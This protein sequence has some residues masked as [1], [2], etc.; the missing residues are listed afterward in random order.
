MSGMRAAAALTWPVPALAA[1]VPPIARAYRVQCDRPGGPA[2]LITFD[3]GPHAQGTPAV[4]DRLD[5]AGTKALFFL[6]GE[7]VERD[8]GLAR[9]V[10]ARGHE[11]G[12]HCH[13]HRNLLR[14][15]ARG[16]RTDLDRAHAAITTA[17]GEEPRLYRPPYGI[18][19][20][21][22]LPE[23]HRRG[24]TLQLW[25]R[26]GRDWTRRATPGTIAARVLRDGPLRPRDVVLL[27]DSDAYSAPGSWQATAA[28]LDRILSR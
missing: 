20:T 25:T 12:V 2:P 4:L 17:T 24:W 15:T 26:W 19:T 7:Q 1:V 6:V 9:E 21:A 22:T 13:R 14:V 27:H 18:L 11:I 3:D 23:V 8:P 16:F 10:L 5:A 28:A